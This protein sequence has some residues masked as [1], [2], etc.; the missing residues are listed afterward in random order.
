MRNVSVTG[1]LKSID[2]LRALVPAPPAMM[3]K[4]IQKEVDDHCLTVIGNSSVCVVGF[5]GQSGIVF[6]NLRDKP[7]LGASGNSIE[8]SWP[9]GEAEPDALKAGQTLACSLYFIMPGIGFTLRANGYCSTTMQ[10]GI[11]TI[12]TFRAEEFFL[13]CSRAKVRANFWEPRRDPPPPE[14]AGRSML[15]DEALSFISRSPYVLLLTQDAAG[16]TDLSPRGDPDGFVWVLDSQTLLVPERPGNKVACTLTN[17]LSHGVLTVAFLIPG[18][19]TL[20]EVNGR[21][22]LTTDIR[23]L[24]PAAIGEKAPKIGIVVHVD[25]YRLRQSQSLADAGLWSKETHLSERDITPFP[26]MLAEHMNGTGL[27]GKA[28]TLLVGAVVKQDLKNLY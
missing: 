4:R 22:S 2:E 15:S 10:D 1:D 7:V 25:T 23:L 13:H 21:C 6:I 12:L 26:Q 3:H 17:I 27:L 20:L 11:G 16:K 18:S 14:G 19:A 28:T 8:L 24:E 5:A 9:E